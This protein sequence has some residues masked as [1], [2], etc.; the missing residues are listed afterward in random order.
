MERVLP[1]MGAPCKWFCSHVMRWA[2]NEERAFA[3]RV[4]WSSVLKA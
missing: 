1:G 4:R 3:V 2:G